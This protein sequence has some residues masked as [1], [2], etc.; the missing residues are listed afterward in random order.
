MF[1]LLVQQIIIFIVITLFV[2]P[3]S[4]TIIVDTDNDGI[5]D[6]DEIKIYKTNPNNPDTDG[7]GYSDWTEL[8]N[9]YSPLMAQSFTLEENDYD[10]DGLSD[11]MELNF[12]TDLTNPDTDGDGYTD[13]EEIKNFYNP[14]STNTEKLDKRIEVNIALQELSYF[15]DGIRMGKMIISSGRARMYT[16]I[17]HFKIEN[18]NPKA[19]SSYGLWMPH[20]MGFTRNGTYGIHELPIWPNGYREGEDSLGKPVSH[21][22]IRLGVNDAEKLY[23]WA[24]IGTPIF[25]Y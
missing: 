22:C 1:K 14:N 23:N 17:G 6:N 5:S 8:N 11:R 4:A 20:W 19:W 25:I 24:N 18:K 9:S 12:R 10:N 2:F 13:G 3:V 21:G 15:L 16:P 7:D